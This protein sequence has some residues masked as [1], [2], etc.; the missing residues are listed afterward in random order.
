[1]MHS[2]VYSLKTSST[3]NTPP[4]YREHKGLQYGSPGKGTPHPTCNSYNPSWIP[5]TY[6][7]VEGRTV[8]TVL[9]SYLHIYAVS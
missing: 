9:S 5:N 2:S 7:K 4:K 6:L 1:M 3:T 8:L